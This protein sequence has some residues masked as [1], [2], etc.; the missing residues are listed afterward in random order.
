MKIVPFISNNSKFSRRKAQELVK[1]GHVRVNGK[2]PQLNQNVN[3]EDEVKVDG[4]VVAQTINKTFLV[5]KPKGV[6][7]TTSDEH[8]RE[9][10]L[11]L[12]PK[13]DIR[14]YPVGR[15]DIESKG[16]MILT[17]DGDFAQK[18]THPSNEIKKTYKV[19]LERQL[20]VSVVEKLKKG[21]KLKDGLAKPDKVTVLQNGKAGCTL[22]I[23]LHEGKNREIRRM[24]GKLGF[25]VLELERI[26]MGEYSLEDLGGKKWVEIN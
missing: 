23:T 17:S 25:K 7:S 10:V 14:L 9:T 24:L 5:Y 18:Y 13:Q 3:S 20:P 15:L 2:R 22:E 16:L 21:L 26:K 8:K 4:H 11:D 1:T 19:T 6:V 12:I